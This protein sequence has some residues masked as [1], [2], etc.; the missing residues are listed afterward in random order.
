[1]SE[2]TI[3]TILYFLL[4]DVFQWLSYYAVL[5]F[6][7][8]PKYNRLYIILIPFAIAFSKPIYPL[9]NNKYVSP[10]ILFGLLILTSLICFREKKPVCLA[11][12]AA[13]QITLAAACVICN[14][15]I[16]N[17]LGYY[18]TEVLPYTWTTIIYILSI[19]IFL[20]LC[21]S[22]MLLLWNRLLKR[23]NTKS[24]A[25]F[26][27]FPVGQMI[28]FW[29]Y[30]FRAWE[31]IDKFILSN[32]YIIAAIVVSVVS[33]I[34]MYKALKQN[35]RAQE[36][37]QT[38]SQLESEMKMQLKYCDALAE[39]YTEIR[40]YRHDIRNLVASAKSL[41]LAGKT[42]ERD[43]LLDDMEERAN[44]LYVPIYCSDPLV[45]AVLWQKETD[46]KKKNVDFTVNMDIA[47]QF[48]ME[49]IDICSLLTNILDNAIDEAAATEQG[50]VTLTVIRKAGVLFI[51]TQ[52]NTNRVIDK[53]V[54]LKSQK[55]GNHGYG[56]VIIKKIAEKYNGCFTLTADGVYAHL[57]VSLVD[58]TNCKNTDK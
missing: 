27:L 55:S 7:L 34:L 4:H 41:S 44:N 6:M 17:I 48:I 2:H 20:W 19:D 3:I 37:K 56:T 1:M 28:F 51:D 46:A 30:I 22:V 31:D 36:M 45:N 52:N 42:E 43:M 18:P 49:K 40:E 23:K 35:S 57:V 10:F 38:I 26:W 24:L 16:Y 13:S 25:Y 29:A 11:A 47:E 21:Y 9:L 53:N 39:Q 8:T 50:R 14:L 12:V 54:I 33:D 5:F 32:P 58:S 15:V